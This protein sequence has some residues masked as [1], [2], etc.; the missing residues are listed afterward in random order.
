MV[1]EN[2]INH[3]Y[4][5]CSELR[6]LALR[7]QR[8]IGS[9]EDI[10]VNASIVASQTGNKARVFFEI[11]SQIEKTSRKMHT[12][13]NTIIHVTSKL[14]ETVLASK[15]AQYHIDSYMLVQI[16]EN[17]SANHE[18]MQ[19]V[20]S[21]LKKQVALGFIQFRNGIKTL[22]AQFNVFEFL[23]NRIF[24]ALTA[25]RIEEEL[26][27]TQLGMVAVGSLIKSFEELLSVLSQDYD[28]FRDYFMIFKHTNKSPWNSEE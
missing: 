5:A 21:R 24:V 7:M 28:V 12:K 25:L 2:N 14:I 19:I 22:E 15:I 1:R 3:H 18:L 17:Y 20:T 9:V 26:F 6:R 13:I 23:I 8:T 27:R 16:P 10:S 4:R 11:S